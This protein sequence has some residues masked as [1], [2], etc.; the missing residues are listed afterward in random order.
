MLESL[1]QLGW[2]CSVGYSY[3]RGG[4]W[5]ACWGREYHCLPGRPH[6][7]R[8]DCLSAGGADADEA[9]AGLI[10]LVGGKR[11]RE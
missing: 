3:E 6:V 9:L 1:R 11:P 10:A 4:W 5:A 7:E 8:L 2:S